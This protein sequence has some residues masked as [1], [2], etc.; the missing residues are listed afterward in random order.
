M[1]RFSAFLAV[2]AVCTTAQ[3]AMAQSAAQPSVASPPASAANPAGA[4]PAY[5]PGSVFASAAN[6]VA[7]YGAPITP[8]QA[9]IVGETAEREKARRGFN[10]T[11]IAVVDPAGRLVYF[12]R[13]DNATFANME[14]AI[15]KARAA[16]RLR[17]PTSL[18]AARLK[19]GDQILLLVPDAFPADG[20][21]PI[22]KDGRLIGA[23]AT[24][25]GIDEQIVA[26]IAA[27][28]V[29]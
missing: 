19:A 3:S 27:Q 12:E 7:P 2:L 6:P 1:S 23:V 5:G 21:E 10:V 4:A 28:A 25:G 29:N 24:A 14:M 16:A 22:I 13:M 18:D 8:E 15:R 17:R 9:R 20:G 26:H 11:A